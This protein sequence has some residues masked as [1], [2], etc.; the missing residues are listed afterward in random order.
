MRR[1]IAFVT[2]SGLPQLAPD[3]RQAARRLEA[4]GARVVAVAWDHGAVRWQDFDLVILRSCWDY[5]LRLDEFRAW[6]DG[7]AACGAMVWNPPGLVRWN[8]DKRYLR[9]LAHA[10]VRTVP[11]RWVE[12]GADAELAGI[13]EEEGW[14]R[15]VVKPVVSASAHATWRTDLASAA[16]DVPRFRELVRRSGVMVQPFLDVIETD[17]ELSLC[18]IGG[19]YSHT[20]RKRP[21]P[22]DFR[23]QSQFGGSSGA[24]EPDGAV[25]RRAREITGAVPGGWLYA[26]VDGCVV[27]GEFWLM[28][29]EMIEP[30]LF[31]DHDPGAP[32][33][34]AAAVLEALER[35]YAPPGA[36]DGDGAPSEGGSR[37]S[38]ATETVR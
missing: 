22:G 1:R 23:V 37:A 8:A 4:K 20:V 7:L 30:S 15:A 31:L 5:H 24:W 3:D 17:G 25:I 9:A 19:R 10:G 14:P 35:G 18:F 34:F 13:L 16:T 6:L 28:E 33:R 27:D 38:N 26:R 36:A 11:T 32:G 29:L 12:R 2:Y 21:R